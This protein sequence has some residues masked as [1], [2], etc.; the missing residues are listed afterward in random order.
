MARWLGVR[1]LI[2]YGATGRLQVQMLEAIVVLTRSTVEGVGKL[3][4]GVCL[5]VTVDAMQGHVD[6][7]SFNVCNGTQ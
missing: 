2:G 4:I 1:K 3:Y 5:S 6:D 7:C